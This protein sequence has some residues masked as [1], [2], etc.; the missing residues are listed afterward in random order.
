MFFFKIALAI[1]DPLSVWIL[2]T[3]CLAKNTAKFFSRN[4]KVLPSEEVWKIST[5]SY[6][7]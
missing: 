4:C 2:G 3:V 1:L 5:I 7:P 6:S